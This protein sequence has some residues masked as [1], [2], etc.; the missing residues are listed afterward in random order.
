[1]G[2]SVVSSEGLLLFSLF[3]TLFFSFLS[4]SFFVNFN[5]HLSPISYNSA[6]PVSDVSKVESCAR[7]RANLEKLGSC[8]QLGTVAPSANRQIG[9]VRGN[10]TLYPVAA[11]T[12]LRGQSEPGG[13]RSEI[14]LLS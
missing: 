1:M 5:L 13:G 9:N 6:F 7:W 14:L 11:S 12:N 4:I 3:L 2:C 8:C 10:S